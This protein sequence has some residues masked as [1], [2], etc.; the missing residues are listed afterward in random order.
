MQ[1]VINSELITVMWNLN[2]I[3]IVSVKFNILKMNPC[4]IREY[5]NE[6]TTI[7][8]MTNR[9]QW[10]AWCYLEPLYTIMYLR[11]VFIIIII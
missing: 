9:I 4:A 7:D 5:N 3:F 10:F 8:S 11:F 2:L 6:K 1:F